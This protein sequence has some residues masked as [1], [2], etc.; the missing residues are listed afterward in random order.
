MITSV[1]IAPHHML[2]IVAVL[3]FSACNP[4]KQ[5]SSNQKRIVDGVEYSPLSVKYAEYFTI[6][7]LPNGHR[8]TVLNPKDKNVS[9]LQKWVF[10]PNSQVKQYTPQPGETVVA[11]PCSKLAMLSDTFIGALELLDVRKLLVATSNTYTLY[12]E[13]LQQYARNGRIASVSPT[14]TI[15]AEQLIALGTDVVMLNYYDGVSTALPTTLPIPVV[16]NNDWLESSLLARAEWIKVIALLVGKATT[17]DS[18]FNEVEVKYNQLK[19]KAEKFA[20]KPRVFF[21]NAYQG[22]WYLPSEKS[23]VAKMISDA[24]GQY[25]APKGDNAQGGLSFEVVVNDHQKDDIWLA[26]QAGTIDSLEDFAAI[27]PRY[28]LFYSYKKGNVYLNDARQKG[29]GNDYFEQAPYRPDL[30]LRDLISI[31]HPTLNNNS[32]DSLYYWRRL[33]SGN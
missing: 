20:H 33:P 31:F 16:Y 29:G 3:F 12:D 19:T 2:L 28:R 18:I 10:L 15:D 22:V 1:R 8:V 6:E 11:V 14:G 26:W 7:N 25:N 17:A 9:P 21:G 24:G 23:Y 13:E 32:S 27:E 30:I 4:S 5:S